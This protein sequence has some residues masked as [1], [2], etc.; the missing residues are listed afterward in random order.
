MPSSRRVWKSREVPGDGLGGRGQC[1][2][3][4]RRNLSFH[5]AAAA[6][7][8]NQLSS[9]NLRELGVECLTACQT[10]NRVIDRDHSRAFGDVYGR[11]EVP[12]DASRDAREP[13]VRRDRV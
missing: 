4:L 8:S 7:T 6:G 12:K 10:P 9:L 1:K 3:Y 2:R 11:G 5:E 13:Q